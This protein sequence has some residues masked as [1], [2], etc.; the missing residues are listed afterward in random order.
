MST[1]EN[2]KPDLTTSQ[3][4]I[5]ALTRAA[6]ILFD[7]LY[8]HPIAADQIIS[9]LRAIREECDLQVGS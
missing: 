3:G 8:S 9:V 1:E 6:F 5:Q 2:K 4:R 7:D